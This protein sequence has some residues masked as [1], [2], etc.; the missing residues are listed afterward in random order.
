MNLNTVPS[1]KKE[2]FSEVFYQRH[3]KHIFRV[4]IK[5]FLLVAVAGA[6]AGICLVSF[7]RGETG[8]VAPSI[9]GAV[10]LFLVWATYRGVRDQLRVRLVPYFERPL[11]SVS[12][13]LAGEKL[14]SYSRQLDE[15]A[16]R[17]G[18]RPLSEFASGDDMIRGEKP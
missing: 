7:L 3:R 1:Q 2:M 4:L 14:L 11:R 6:V 8:P 5:L 16:V 10:F 18:V 9:S 13:F 12:S 17:L 15:K